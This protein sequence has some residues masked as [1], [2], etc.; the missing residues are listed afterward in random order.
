MHQKQFF[1]ILYVHV[2]SN[3]QYNMPHSRDV[4]NDFAINSTKIVTTL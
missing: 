2:L 3:H 1:R 4:I